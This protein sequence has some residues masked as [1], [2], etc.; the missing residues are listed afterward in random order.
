[1]QPDYFRYL[2]RLGSIPSPDMAIYLESRFL[3]EPREAN[4]IL[5][6]WLGLRELVGLLVR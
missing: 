3:I 4:E 1:M 6:D 2:D 5:A